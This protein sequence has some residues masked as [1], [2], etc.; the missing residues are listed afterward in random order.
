MLG[1]TLVNLTL[2][3]EVWEALAVELSGVLSK[4]LWIEPWLVFSRRRLRNPVVGRPWLTPWC[5]RLDTPW[6]GLDTVWP[7]HILCPGVVPG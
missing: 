7:W 5:D 4:L 6:A 1:G 2:D 3:D